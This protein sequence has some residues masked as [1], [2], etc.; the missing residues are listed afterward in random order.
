MIKID[1]EKTSEDGLLIYRDAIHL[2]DDHTLSD[3]DIEAIKQT[4]FDRWYIAVT[5]PAVEEVQVD[6]IPTD[7]VV[8]EVQVDVIPADPVVEDIPVQE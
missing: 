6:V 5:T 8:E 7:P 4:R 2:E 1:F 3:A